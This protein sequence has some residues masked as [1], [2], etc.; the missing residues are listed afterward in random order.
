MGDNI[1]LGDRNGVR[2][3]MQW[4]PDRNGGFSRCDPQRLYLPPIMDAVYG[5]QAVNVEAHLRDRSPLLHW[6]R[7]M[8]AVRRSHASFGRGTLAFVR[9]GNRKVLAYLR[10]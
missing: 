7:R 10:E 4:S 1:F 2:T 9:P 3:P 8:L 5:Y 6:M